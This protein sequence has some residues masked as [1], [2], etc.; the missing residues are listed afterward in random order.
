MA[1]RLDDIDATQQTAAKVAG[2]AY[3]IP[4]AFIVY[5]NFGLRGPLFVTG[6][7]AET[8]R[9]IAA[10]VPTYRLSV[11]FDLV[12][13]VGVIVLLSALYVVFR[14]VNRYLAVLATTLKLVYAVTAMLMVLSWI[15]IARLVTTPVY[16]QTLGD[17]HL[18]AL[19]K[20]NTSAT[21]DEYYVGLA[22]WAV[23]ATIIGWL[24]LKSQYIPKPLALFGLVSA[25]WCALCTFAFIANPATSQVVNLWWFDSPLAVFDII[26]SFWLLFKGLRQTQSP[27]YQTQLPV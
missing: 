5:A 16:A 25:A 12:Y 2:L 14:P 19:V 21:M 4:V 18:Q 8:M 22:F 23:S 20:L 1:E 17:E 10:A 6:D 15:T 7:T 3:L 27:A 9:R 11:V 26:L 13:C 24:W